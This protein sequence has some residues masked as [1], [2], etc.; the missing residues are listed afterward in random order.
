MNANNWA[1][2]LLVAAVALCCLPMMFRGRR[3]RGNSHDET[4]EKSHK[5]G[6]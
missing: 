1:L 2:I 6:A 4:H 5:P 3:H